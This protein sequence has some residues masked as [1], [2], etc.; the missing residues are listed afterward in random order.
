MP[1]PTGITEAEVDASA[2]TL[3]YD[4]YGQL[5]M[6]ETPVGAHDEF[7][8]VVVSRPANAAASLRAEA[9]TLT[10]P[11]WPELAEAVLSL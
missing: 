4:E 10:K 6:V 7:V 11:F 2:R 8:N 3:H 5:R 9:G 1:L